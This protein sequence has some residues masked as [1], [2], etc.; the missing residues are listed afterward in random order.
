MNQ[1]V[2]SSDKDFKAAVIKM[3]QQSVAKSLE[4]NEKIKK[5]Q[6]RNGSYKKNQEGII[7]LKKYSNRRKKKQ[8]TTLTERVQVQSG[9][10]GV[11]SQ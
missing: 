1:M 5:S 7:K 11:W 9:D 8:K 10:D 3:L 4:T 6:Q 2:E